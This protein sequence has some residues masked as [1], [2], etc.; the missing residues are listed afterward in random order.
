MN[1]QE[2]KFDFEK[3]WQGK[4]SRAVEKELGKEPR[5]SVLQGGE[6][7]TDG[8]NTEE[9]VSWTCEALDQLAL[10]TDEQTRQEILTQC[11]CKYPV[12]DLQ[13]VKAAYKKGGDVDLALSMLQEKFE[14]FL[15]ETLGL[16][17]KLIKTILGLGWGVAGKREG[18][19]IIATKIPKSG[20]LEQYFN[21]ADPLQKRRYYCHCP[22]VRDGV[23]ADPTLP[24]TYCYCGAGFYKGIWEEIL[25]ET[26]GVEMLE[27]V[28]QGDEVCKIAV[29][30]PNKWN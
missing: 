27:S 13:D 2:E 9:K 19:T 24:M 29:H 30:L 1:D 22:R 20:Y 23:G 15:R 18:Q 17:E 8:S 11:A 26:V 6:T 5:D 3:N 7:L 10:I 25:G 21:E 16:E 12:E 14:F 4:F 28:L